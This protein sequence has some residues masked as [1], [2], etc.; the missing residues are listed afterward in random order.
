MNLINDSDMYFLN[1]GSAWDYIDS[2][3]YY[4]YYFILYV[5]VFPAAVMG[6]YVPLMFADP[7]SSLS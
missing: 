6:I 5:T 2:T 3:H 1:W 7:P 4:R